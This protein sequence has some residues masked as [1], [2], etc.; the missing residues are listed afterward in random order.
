ML[1]SLGREFEAGMQLADVALASIVFIALASR[2]SLHT[3]GADPASLVPL[4][5]VVDFVSVTR[6]IWKRASVTSSRSSLPAF[7]N[8]SSSWATSWRSA[9]IA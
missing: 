8:S 9:G 4:A 5:L 1:K 7:S 6:P 2:P 3:A